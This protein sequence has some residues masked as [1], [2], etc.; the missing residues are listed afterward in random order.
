M[1][2]G[3]HRTELIKHVT[4]GLGSGRDGAAESRDG[5]VPEY[6]MNLGAIPAGERRLGRA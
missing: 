6:A 1:S 5:G 2:E 4:C 3:S